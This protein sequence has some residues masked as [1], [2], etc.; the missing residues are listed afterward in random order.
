MMTSAGWNES[1]SP[2]FRFLMRQGLHET[3]IRVYVMAGS[4]VP[5][6]ASEVLSMRIEPVIGRSGID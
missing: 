4:S 5:R 2:L 3:M 6:V 1:R